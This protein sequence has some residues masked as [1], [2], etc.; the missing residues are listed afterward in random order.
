MHN[1]LGVQLFSSACTTVDGDCGHPFDSHAGCPHETWTFTLR[2]QLQ[3]TNPNSKTYIL[4]FW[5]L[6]PYILA[7]PRVLED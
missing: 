4:I 6:R 3:T 1:A 2:K 5:G 7:H